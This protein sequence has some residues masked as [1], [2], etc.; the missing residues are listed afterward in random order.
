[1]GDIIYDSNRESI[2]GLCL[3]KI[4]KDGQNLRRGSVFRAK[5]IASPYDNWLRYLIIKHL[6]NIKVKRLSR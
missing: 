6:Q 1:M 2:L 4:V 3:F 5:A